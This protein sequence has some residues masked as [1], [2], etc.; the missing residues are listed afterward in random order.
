MGRH[1]IKNDINAD[2][3]LQLSHGRLNPQ[4]LDPDGGLGCPPLTLRISSVYKKYG[5][6]TEI[7]AQNSKLDVTKWVAGLDPGTLVGNSFYYDGKFYGAVKIIR[8]PYSPATKEFQPELAV[9]PADAP[10]RMWNFPYFVNQAEFYR[11]RSP[12]YNYYG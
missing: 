5:A 12:T 10:F 2:L 7:W 3:V 1:S 11:Y 8:V 9:F 6:I 4:F